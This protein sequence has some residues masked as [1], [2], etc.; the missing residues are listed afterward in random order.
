[1]RGKTVTKAVS[2]VEEEVTV[3]IHVPKGSKLPLDLN[4]VE[5]GKEHSMTIR[6]PVRS[7]SQD[8]YGRSMGMKIDGIEHGG[9]SDSLGDDLKKARAK[10]RAGG[11]D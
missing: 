3:H 6:G 2:D 10:R 5:I 4:G 1:M 11:A 8:E 9:A 7:V